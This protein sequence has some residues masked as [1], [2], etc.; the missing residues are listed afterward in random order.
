MKNDK[1]QMIS[2]PTASL[3]NN[4]GAIQ[5][6]LPRNC[7]NDAPG[8]DMTKDKGLAGLRT[9]RTKDDRKKKLPA[10][11][12]REV[13]IRVHLPFISSGVGHPDRETS[14]IGFYKLP[15]ASFLPAHS[16]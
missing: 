3:V 1:G 2:S 4:W 8:L 16:S 11:W 7:P 15:L 6:W 9:R 10:G 14:A 5:E 12:S 13:S